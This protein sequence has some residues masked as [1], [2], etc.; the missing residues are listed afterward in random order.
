MARAGVSPA[1][2]RDELAEEEPAHKKRKGLV[3]TTLSLALDGAIFGSS[4]A[5]S[6]YQLW[7]NPPYVAL[8]RLRKCCT[9]HLR[10]RRTVGDDIDAHLARNSAKSSA[11]NS[12]LVDAP[13]PYTE[14]VRNSLAVSIT[15]C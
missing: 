11:Q 5:Y 12:P 8:P 2:E 15:S 4:V 9:N 7:K 6:A 3:G 10:Q 13:P 14:D 1:T